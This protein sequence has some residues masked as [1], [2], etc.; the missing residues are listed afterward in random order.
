MNYPDWQCSSELPEIQLGWREFEPYRINGN[1]RSLLSG[2]RVAYVCPS[3]HLKGLGG[4][5]NIDSYDVVIRA[6][7]LFPLPESDY[8]DYGS[9]T[10]ILTHSFNYIE[11]EE[12]RKHMAYLSKLKHIMCCVVSCGFLSWHEEFFNELRF[13]GTSVENIDD[14]YLFKLYREI[15]TTASQGYSGL[16]AL[17]HYDIKEIFVTGMTFY[18][19]GKYG[20]V[21]SDSYY[22]SVTEK[23]KIYAGNKDKTSTP[24]QSRVDLHNQEAQIEHF[25][26]LSDDRIILDDYLTEHFR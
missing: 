15:G 2:K 17:L 8:K 7:Q 13:L 4:G 24:A 14:A 3:P 5:E 6:G 10:D 9:R 19:M 25:R 11:I 20:N 21:Y 22:E 23:Q 18:N 16:M 1:L 12:A 26:N